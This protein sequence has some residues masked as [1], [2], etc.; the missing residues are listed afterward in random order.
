MSNSVLEQ[1]KTL[2][3]IKELEQNPRI[4]QRDLA[5]KLDIS[6]GKMNFLLNALIEKGVIEAKNFKNSKNKLAYMYL[7]TSRGV[8]IK[9]DLMQKF[10]IWKLQEFERLKREIKDFKKEIT[11]INLPKNG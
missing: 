2:T 10:F 6:L 3:V 4:T 11:Q 8:K 9:I 5:Q 1:E 7:L